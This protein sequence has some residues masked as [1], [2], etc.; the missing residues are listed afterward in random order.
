[1]KINT[2]ADMAQIKG[3]MIEDF[4]Y[5]AA[6]RQI[7]L[8]VSSILAPNKVRIRINQSINFAFPQVGV[9]VYTPLVMFN[10][11]E[12]PNEV[13]ENKEGSNEH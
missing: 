13:V 5:D 1:M 9:I 12:I 8:E 4:R 2:P 10:T 3:W 7:V 11:E 6:A